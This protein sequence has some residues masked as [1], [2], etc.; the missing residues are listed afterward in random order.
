MNGGPV[1]QVVSG[2]VTGVDLSGFGPNSGEMT[3]NIQP[4]NKPLVQVFA[5]IMNDQHTPTSIE[6]GMFAAY[7]NMALTAMTTGRTLSLT[8]L[9]EDKLR[10]NWMTI[11]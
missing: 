4:D 3:L 10:I 11:R 5:G 1:P 9:A 2:V 7:V 8:Y 6:N